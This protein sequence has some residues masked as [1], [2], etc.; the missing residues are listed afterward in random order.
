MSG[1]FSLLS[2]LA[3]ATEVHNGSLHIIPLRDVDLT[4]EL[5]AARDP[6]AH[7]TGDTLAFWHWLAECDPHGHQDGQPADGEAA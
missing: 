7:A 5:H 3:V 4:R 1:G 6:S 2:R